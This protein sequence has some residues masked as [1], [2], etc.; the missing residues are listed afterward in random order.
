MLFCG[1][2]ALL[3][4]DTIKLNGSP[5]TGVPGLLSA[6]VMYPLFL[7]F[8]SAFIWV[9]SA[10]GLWAFSWFRKMEL[11]FVDGAVIEESMPQ[12]FDD[13]TASS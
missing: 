10:L 2:A 9:G 5:V 1:I 3:G 12:Q 4:S 13:L 7:F 11:D 8:F 6:V